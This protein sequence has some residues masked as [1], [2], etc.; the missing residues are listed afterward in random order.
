MANES[1]DFWTDILTVLEP[2]GLTSRPSFYSDGEARAAD[3]Q[4]LITTIFTRTAPGSADR[5]KVVSLLNGA[6]FWAEGDRLSFWI[7]IDANAPGSAR[8]IES[9]VTVAPI[10]LP[11]LSFDG[12][13]IPAD[14]SPR[15]TG[16]RPGGELTRI[17]F[18]DKDDVWAMTYTVN[19]IEHVYTFGSEEA[20]KAAMGAD[21]ASRLGVKILNE[22]T[23]NDGDTWILGDA[24]GH[25]G[26]DQAYAGYWDDIMREAALEAGIRNPGMLGDYLADPDIQR[27][28]AMG[29]AGKWSGE[30]VQAEV[31]RTDFYLETLYP[32]IESMLEAGL[33]NPEQQYNQYMS[34][35]D[36]SL[37]SLGYQRDSDGTFRSQVGSMLEKG[38]KAEQ[39]VGFA[40]TFIKAQ[41]NAEFG[42]VLSAW[43]Q[44]DLGVALDFSNWFDVIDG[45]TSP[46]IDE[47]VQKAQIA[48][49]GQQGLL[50][51]SDDIISRVAAKTDLTAAQIN[52]AFTSGEQALFALGDKG[53]A[54]SGLTT[55]DLINA[56][57]DLAGPAGSPQEIRALSRKVATELGLRDD[58]KAKFF[59][60]FNQRGVPI[61]PGLAASRPEAG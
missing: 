52:A 61:T 23:V 46:E 3:Y 5:Q 38:I 9:L 1:L 4:N 28:M 21:A 8:D 13:R 45:N 26:Q 33:P 30:R 36:A 7:N 11:D 56:P 42:S 14:G 57:L 50:G 25:A 35:V 54:I 22:S 39:F 43:T 53:L 18:P 19:G 37:D 6:G 29:A 58:P 12:T 55:E 27:I 44:R 48:F 32:G 16:I 41:T 31:R 60:S 10:R 20:M 51:L 40:P 49:R 47:V 59:N 34:T 2:D 17:V 24:E 15:P